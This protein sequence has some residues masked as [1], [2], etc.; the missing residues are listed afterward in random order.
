MSVRWTTPPTDLD[1]AGWARRVETAV[2]QIARETAL[3]MEAD[4]RATAPWKDDTG[5]ARNG[6]VSD[7]ERQGNHLLITLAHS[8]EYGPYL[9]FSRGG[10]NAIIWPTIE[11]HAPALIQRLRELLR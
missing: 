1:I 3:A 9:E 2:T 4:A 8:V 11:Q 7:T 5:A 10:K 6:L